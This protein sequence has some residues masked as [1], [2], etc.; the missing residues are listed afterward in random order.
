MWSKFMLQVLHCCHCLRNVTFP[1]TPPPPFPPILLY[2]LRSRW[3]WGSCLYM[4]PHCVCVCVCFLF[5]TCLIWYK[6]LLLQ[7]FMH[8]RIH[9]FVHKLIR[10]K[11]P[12]ILTLSTAAL[13]Q[14][15]GLQFVRLL[16]SSQLSLHLIRWQTISF[17]SK[18]FLL[19]WEFF[20]ATPC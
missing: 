5:C 17:L 20:S 1:V 10:L 2:S 19:G 9:L 4:I 3:K 11:S 6:Y 16:K 12:W 18:S 13:R 14:P 7:V 15:S 8:Y